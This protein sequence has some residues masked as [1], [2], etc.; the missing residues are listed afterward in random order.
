MEG[1]MSEN[2]ITRSVI[3]FDPGERAAWK[4]AQGLKEQT[5][6]V[7]PTAPEDKPNRPENES[8]DLYLQWL[9]DDGHITHHEKNLLEASLSPLR[10]DFPELITIAAVRDEIDRAVPLKVGTRTLSMIETVAAREMKLWEKTN[11]IPDFDLAAQHDLFFVDGNTEAGNVSFITPDHVHTLG[12]MIP[13][14]QRNAEIFFWIILRMYHLQYIRDNREELSHKDQFA[15][16]VQEISAFTRETD[17]IFE[18]H[19]RV[20]GPESEQDAADRLPTERTGPLSSAEIGIPEIRAL[21]GR[22][23]QSIER[24]KARD[25]KKPAPTDDEVANVFADMTDLSC[26]IKTTTDSF[27]RGEITVDKAISDVRETLFDP[28]VAP[29][30]K[31]SWA[32][33]P[34]PPVEPKSKVRRAIENLWQAIAPK[35]F[36]RTTERRLRKKT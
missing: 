19:A 7:Q 9:L 35:S 11:P 18:A 15:T 27:L 6:C 17:L 10:L 5:Q 26:P 23:L 22:L 8:V 24:K 20:L 12:K 14:H 25:A 36:W 29:E 4:Q 32:P 3:P 33:P 13:P 16:L 28:T 34:L 2:E 31:S 30:N 21:H 1:I